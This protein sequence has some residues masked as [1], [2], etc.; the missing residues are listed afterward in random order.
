M[1]YLKINTNTSRSSLFFNSKL[2]PGV[3]ALVLGNLD[4]KKELTISI[5]EV[6]DIKLSKITKYG[7]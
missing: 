7:N 5:V 4:V 1:D 3:S 6:S 2:L